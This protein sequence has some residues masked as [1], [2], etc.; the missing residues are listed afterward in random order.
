MKGDS[1]IVAIVAHQLW[2]MSNPKHTKVSHRA[3]LATIIV[4]GLAVSSCQAAGGGPGTD[5][6]QQTPFIGPMQCAM[7]LPAGPP[8]KP[9]RMRALGTST[10]WNVGRN[11]GR[12]VI[13]GAGTMVAGPAGGAAAGAL[14]A[15]TIRSEFDPRGSW[16]AT[17]GAR[18]CGCALALDGSSGWTAGTPAR[19]TVSSTTCVNSALA[20]ANDWRLDETVTG[21]D[22]EL[23]IY[24]RNGNRIAVL[25]RDSAD[26]YSGQLSDGRP[27]TIWRQ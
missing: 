21:L 6:A 25:K 5:I 9:E 22:A 19:G 14:A 26:Y 15:R 13:A 27:L 18:D 8:Q 7:A 10:A 2:P 20:E 24:A 12:G 11:V 1:P 3:R 23:L 4:A 17:D 16:T